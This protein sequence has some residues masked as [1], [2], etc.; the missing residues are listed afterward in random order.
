MAK[1]KTL[2]EQI[3]TPKTIK[4]AKP[5]VAKLQKPSADQ[6]ITKRRQKKMDDQAG[7]GEVL[8]NASLLE[9]EAAK[10]EEYWAEY[11]RKNDIK[12]RK[13]KKKRKP[14]PL[15]EEQLLARKIKEQQL[16]LQK[17]FTKQRRRVYNIIRRETL[18]GTIEEGLTP[19]DVIGD[20][21]LLYTPERIAEVTNITP[22]QVR[23]RYAKKSDVPG[24]TFEPSSDT[25]S[26]YLPPHQ[27]DLVLRQLE[28]MIESFEI[29]TGARQ[30]VWAKQQRQNSRESLRNILDEAIARDGRDTVAQRCENNPAILEYAERLLMES[31]GEVIRMMLSY[32]VTIITGRALSVD[33]SKMLGEYYD[34]ATD[35]HDGEELEDIGKIFID[36]FT[37]ETV[38]LDDLEEIT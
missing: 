23:E 32:I 30:T 31:R 21:P 11:H 17:Q 38:N 12:G 7:T 34:S 13:P 18:K 15:T 5:E 35:E 24:G 29:E 6:E 9:K 22:Q 3:P 8:S 28:Q 4:T 2:T 25:D 26:T 27:T 37:G 16:E 19:E 20:R 36:P 14:K 1:K 10:G 33:E